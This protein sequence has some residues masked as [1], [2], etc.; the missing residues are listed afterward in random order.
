MEIYKVKRFSQTS[1]IN[2]GPTALAQLLS[3]YGAELTPEKIETKT[4]MA[5]NG[6]L[7][8]YLGQAAAV[9]GYKTKITPQNMFVFD[10]TWYKLPQDKLTE[11]L[12]KFRETAKDKDVRFSIDGYLG[13]LKAGGKIEFK[14]LSKE[15]LAR[16]TAKHPILIGFCLNC[17]YNDERPMAPDQGYRYTHFVIIN[18]YDPKSDKFSIVDP[19]HTIPFAKSGRYKV[20]SDKL[21]QAMLLAEA[22]RDCTIIE[23]E[24]I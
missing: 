21:I 13:F 15:L 8:G 23:I 22:M 16:K 17:I 18:G 12:Q 3:Y 9:F 4:V 11:K 7:D 1:E 10:P 14:I 20:K 24:N 5:K 19:Y 6:T 2:C